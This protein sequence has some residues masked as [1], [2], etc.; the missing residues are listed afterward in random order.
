MPPKQKKPESSEA[1]EMEG[2]EE[3]EEDIE[4]RPLYFKVVYV[5]ETSIHA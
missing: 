2:K 4:I 1:A 3:K 5:F